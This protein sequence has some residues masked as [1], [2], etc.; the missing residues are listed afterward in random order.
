MQQVAQNWHF[1][2]EQEKKTF[3]LHN[4]FIFFP[5]LRIKASPVILLFLK[6]FSEFYPQFSAE[7]QGA[8]SQRPGTKRRLTALPL[9][10][11]DKGNACSMIIRPGESP[12]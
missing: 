11:R 1:Q 4:F 6:H 5:A 3:L 9:R 10:K 2:M 7:Q 12:P 8:V